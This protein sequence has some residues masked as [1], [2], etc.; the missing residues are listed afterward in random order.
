[1][2]PKSSR[3]Q[4]SLSVEAAKAF[5]PPGL[6]S[7]LSKVLHDFKKQEAVIAKALKACEAPKLLTAKR[8]AISPW[9]KGTDSEPEATAATEKNIPRGACPLL[10]RTAMGSTGLDSALRAI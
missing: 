8:C 1:M 9:Q 6:N 7:S 2:V 3:K 10:P 5:E 4:R